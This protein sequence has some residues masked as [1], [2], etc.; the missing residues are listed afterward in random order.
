VHG[1]NRLGAN[2]LLD[3]VI[4]G[5]AAAK[6]TVEDL[7][8]GATQKELPA[9]CGEESI[10]RLD[11]L[12]YSSGTHGT[13]QIRLA[14]Q[15]VMQR[16]AAVFR[17]Q[18]LLEEGCDKIHEIS[19]MYKDIGITDRGEVW[20]TDLVE[21][22]ELENLLI[23]SKMTVFAAEAR[24]ESRGAHARDDFPDRD[25]KDWMVH[26]MADLSNPFDKPTLSYREVHHMPLND[27]VAHV[28]PMKRVY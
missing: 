10:A 19:H 18:D 26:T 4:F 6:T 16:N 22:F 3:L 15:K 9:N 23:Q 25:D 17:R 11:K 24:K 21:A 8:P 14:M 7:K 28:P 13:A 1:A 5:R 27:E 12:R 2:S 20:N